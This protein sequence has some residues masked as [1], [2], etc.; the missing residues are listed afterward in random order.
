MA[1]AQGIKGKGAGGVAGDDHQVWS[2]PCDGLPDKGKD[3]CY[4]KIISLFPIGKNGRIG[5]VVDACP[6]K[7]HPEAAHDSQAADT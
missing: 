4:Q 6:R 7:V 1:R 3:A 5:E 2:Q